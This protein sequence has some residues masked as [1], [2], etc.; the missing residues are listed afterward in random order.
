MTTS[1]IN[2]AIEDFGAIVSS[3]LVVIGDKLGLYRTLRDIGPATAAQLSQTAGANERYIRPWLIN[4]AAAG[5][6]DYDPATDRYS[7]S[8]EQAMVFADDDTPYS[9]AGGFELLT[10]AIKAEP[11]IAQ[12]MKSG[13]GLLW[14]DHDHGLF[15]GT[16]RF[17]KPGYLGNIAQN[18]LPALDGVQAKLERGAMV[19]DVGCG[20]GVSTVIMAQAYP[21]SRFIG[22]DNHA[23]SIAAARKAAEEAGV[24]ERVTFE[25]A[26]AQS[27]PGSDYDLVTVFDALHDM[28]DPV[29]AARHAR[30]ALKP[31][32][33]VMLVEPMAGEKVEDNLNIVGRLY[34][35]ASV[36]VCTPHAIAE[37]GQALGTIAPESELRR[38]F[39]TAG[40]STF[41]RATESPTNRVFEAKP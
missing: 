23:P 36:L 20:Y 37:G 28:G 38:V 9:M 17:F 32:G 7:L 33:T 11:R 4:Q 2:R 31:D 8:A 29:G 14:S 1:Q 10:S 6:V 30:E 25:I 35:A 5:Y 24:S 3:A 13:G 16:A 40:Y 39:E 12:A 18:W 15:S 19:A 22:F 27:F 26:A 21:N 41:R 34:S